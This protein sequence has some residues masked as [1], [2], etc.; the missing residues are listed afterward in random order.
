MKKL[1]LPFLLCLYLTGCTVTVDSTSSATEKAAVK[2]KIHSLSC[3]QNTGWD[4]FYFTDSYQLL[5]QTCGVKF[6][7]RNNGKE[8][9]LIGQF[10][11]L[12][13]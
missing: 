12:E 2:Y 6:V 3:N 10:R 9:V 7:N 5:S 8:V 11:I 1:L 13:Q 4:E